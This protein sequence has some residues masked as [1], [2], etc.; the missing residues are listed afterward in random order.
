MNNEEA[1]R[2]LEEAAN[3]HLDPPTSGNGDN[4]DG[5]EEKTDEEIV[6][7][8]ATQLVY[9]AF[10]KGGV[11]LFNTGEDGGEYAIVQVKGHREVWPV[12]S[13]RFQ[14]Y[15]EF[16]WFDQ[17]KT[18]SKTMAVQEAL[19]TLKAIA[20]YKSKTYPVHLRIAEHDDKIYVDLAN[21]AWEVV[22]ISADGW[23][24][25]SESP[26]I[27]W[28]PSSMRPLPRPERGGSISQFTNLLPT[29]SRGHQVLVVAF[30]FATYR[31][32]IAYPLLVL[33]GEQG[34]GK[35]SLSKILR[36]LVDPNKAD[37]RSPPRDE[38]AAI[39]AA[40]RG[41]LLAFDNLSH[42]NE[43]LSDVFC[44][45]ST[46]GGLS[47]RQLY[48]D[49]DEIIVEVQRPLILNGIEEFVR[50][51]DLLDRSFLV[52]LPS[53]GKNRRAESA[54]WAE[55]NEVRPAILGAI[56][57]VVAYALAHL[58]D[59]HLTDLPRLTD[60]ALWLT[61][62]EPALGWKPGTFLDMYKNNAESARE[63]VIESSPVAA[64]VRSLMEGRREWKGAAT[65]LLKDLTDITDEPTRRRK[66]WPQSPSSLGNALRRVQ[67]NLR[68]IGIL[69]T[70]ERS[71][72]C[73]TIN[74][75]GIPSVPS[76]LSEPASDADS[77]LTGLQDS[78]SEV[79]SPSSPDMADEADIFAQDSSSEDELERKADG[80][81][82]PG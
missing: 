34:A 31:A 9:L 80:V 63:L 46:G 50:R 38:D 13:Q 4:S 41:W 17:E 21:D 44:R 7:N 70:F 14:R 68:A 62:A 42:L 8:Q 47:K 77:L 76:V 65:E 78:P 40:N 53:L 3:S 37:L 20:I 1:L 60:V 52:E 2:K 25:I 33:T 49:M 22:E 32:R 59:V 43:N 82:R 10:T 11:T 6:G 79:S 71:E 12:G 72:R 19:K 28:R 29:L 30:L 35:S 81:N 54:L 36:E 5:E 18:A 57:D 66:S 64:A 39:I 45:L 15:L 69:V 51:G 73:R 48:T 27:F 61:A 24:V 67:P 55:F 23:R 16:L 56:Y 26:V 75:S 74:I 58:K